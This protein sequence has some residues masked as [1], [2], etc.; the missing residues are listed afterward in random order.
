M[1]E[2]VIGQG[3]LIEGEVRGE[4]PV[5]V[6]G[7]VRGRIE[8]KGTVRV[9]KG[10]AVEADIAGDAVAIAGAVTGNVVASDKVELQSECRVV[11]D[12]RSPR[13][14][15]ADGACF[16]GSVDMDLGRERP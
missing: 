1:A 5:V 4:A 8:V 6:R 9:E 14:H 11:G 3:L 13:I 16:K 15:I 7:T 2:T 12:I 10:A